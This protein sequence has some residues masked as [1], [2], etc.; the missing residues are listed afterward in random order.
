M[1]LIIL[2]FTNEELVS[3][4]LYFFRIGFQGNQI[5]NFYTKIDGD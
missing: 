5:I 3:K 4:I 1:F 2:F